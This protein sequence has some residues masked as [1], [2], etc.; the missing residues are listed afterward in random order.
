V[1]CTLS[2]ILVVAVALL[3]AH[4]ADRADRKTAGPTDHAVPQF[5]AL[6][7]EGDVMT[8]STVS[9]IIP[10]YNYARTLGL[11]IEA[12]Q[13]QTH[14]PI[15]IIVVDDCS[16]DDS[17]AVATALGVQVFS[18]PGNSGVA[19]ARNLGVAHATGEVLFFVDSDVALA[20]DAL[21]QTLS[22]LAANPDAG[23]VC[24]IY[25]PEP[26]IRDSRVEEYRSL[27]AHYWRLSSEGVVTFGFFSLGAIRSEVFTELGPFNTVLKQTEEVEYGNR[28]SQKYDLLLTSTVRGRHDDDHELWPLLRKLFRR[29]RLRV[30]LYA[31]RR[32]FA[33][34]FETAS[35]AWSSL[36]ALAAVLLIP[37]P[38]LFG[39]PFAV[40][41]L[42][43]L[44]LSILG[45]AGM[46]AFV[47]RRRGP[48]FG[49]YFTGVHFLVNL[50]ISAG[51]AAG[52]VNWLFSRRFRALYGGESLEMSAAIS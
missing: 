44:A 7:T 28:L 49:L 14:P 38:L 8:G 29:G 27:Q 47:L 2:E 3:I 23:S 9:V 24:G 26:L 1:V 32:R 12:V 41:P 4:R 15:E 18:T 19:A 40:L 31:E 25:D 20:P 5:S 36:A 39:V 22:M 35:R 13:A 10:N 50:A 46:Y 21:T 52:A 17:V 6:P 16:T 30:P 51:V 33:K 34:G 43:F 45:D 42:G 37:V 48:L 11:C